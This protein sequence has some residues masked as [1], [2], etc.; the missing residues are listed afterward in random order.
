MKERKVELADVATVMGYVQ[1]LY[2]ALSNSYLPE[3][4]AF[5][6]GFVKGA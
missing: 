4:K 2:N 5:I 1:D 3:K 6:K